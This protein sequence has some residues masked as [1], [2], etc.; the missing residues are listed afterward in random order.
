MMNHNRG[1]TLIEMLVALGIGAAISVMA[2]Q[3][4]SGTIRT[5]ERVTEVTKEIEQIDRAW[6]FIG[7]DLRHAVARPWLNQFKQPQPA[8]FGLLGDRQAQS[9]SISTGN[10][11]YLLRFVR[12]GR[13]NLFDRPRS[14]LEIVAYR[15]ALDDSSDDAE[16]SFDG[17]SVDGNSAEGNIVLW[18]DYWSPIDSVSEPTIKSR[19]LLDNITTISFRYLAQNSSSTKDEAWITGWPKTSGASEEL[20]LAVEVTMEL[21][22]LGEVKRLFELTASD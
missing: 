7:E 11:T 20:P 18:R 4:L 19:R 16:N 6:K 15:I 2:Y 10:D 12:S 22:S 21:K 8:M 17:N 5:E 1:F 13:H 14:D 3:A 9:S